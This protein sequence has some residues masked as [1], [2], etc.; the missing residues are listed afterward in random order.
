MASIVTDVIEATR[1]LPYEEKVRV[2]VKYK[3]NENS[4]LFLNSK[5]DVKVASAIIK[6]YIT[7]KRQ[8]LLTK[9]EIPEWYHGRVIKNLPITNGSVVEIKKKDL[10]NLIQDVDI[11]IVEIDHLVYPMN[12]NLLENDNVVPLEQTIHCGIERINAI[13]YHKITK[14]SGIKIGIIDSGVYSEHEDLINNIKG[15]YNFADNSTDYYDDCG[16]GT[17]VAGIIVA[18]DNDYGIIGVAP[19]ASLYILK[20]LKLM[21]GDCRAFVS[22]SIEAVEW[23]IENNIDIVSMSFGGT[24]YS[25][26]FNNTLDMAYAAGILLIASAGNA[27]QE[28]T[29]DDCVKY[30]AAY[31]SVIAVGATKC[32]DEY[33]YFSSRGP[34]VE[35]VAPGWYIHTTSNDG[36]Y[37]TS[38]T[39]TSASAPFIS[40]MCALLMSAHPELDNTEIRSMLQDI[41]VDLGGEGRDTTFGYGIPVLREG[42]IPTPGQIHIAIIKEFDI[43]QSGQS[44]NIYVHVSADSI[45]LEHAVIGIEILNLIKY[46]DVNGNATFVYTAPEVTTDEQITINIISFKSGYLNASESTIIT[47]IP[48][49]DCPIPTCTFILP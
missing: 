18:E 4:E 29:Y 7:T 37:T 31:D 27:G 22:D 45:P 42:E 49:T 32:N 46:S 39:G 34:E 25:T 21:D 10:D 20:N 33:A 44:M 19:E 13:N 16:H 14:G 48:Q 12:Y 6:Q 1:Y 5:Q 17:M 8:R 40:G 3:N 15:G 11:E 30:P 23:A 28:C 47:V 9:Q 26:T 35:F 38:F 24:S 2:I 43:I 41:V 36:A